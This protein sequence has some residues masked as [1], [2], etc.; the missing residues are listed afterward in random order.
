MFLG[1]KCWRGKEL[2]EEWLRETGI[3]LGLPL[4]LVEREV[5][6]YDTLE[7]ICSLSPVPL[8]LKGGTLISRLYSERPRFSWDIDLSAN[9]SSK[10]ALDLRSLNRS[11]DARRRMCSLKLGGN[12]RIKFGEIVRD[13]EKDVFVDL[14]S[15]K[16]DM[17]TWNLGTPLPT[18]A[19]KL[20]LRF[21]KLRGRLMELKRRLGRLPLV[22]SVRLTVSL[23]LPESAFRKRKVRSLLQSQ[24]P[25]ARTVRAPVYPPEFCLLEKLA[26]MSKELETIGMRDL[27][28]DFY[29]AGQ[30]LKL[31]LF[32][33]RLLSYGRELYRRKALLS[34]ETMRRRLERNL[35]IIRMNLDQLKK[36]REFIWCQY[37]WKGYFAATTR[38]IKRV[39]NTLRQ[40]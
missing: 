19:K 15:L 25:P 11:L 40:S 2:A 34:P 39:L 32:K 16:R 28:C 8:V 17:L 20:G 35:S 5:V 9:L 10:E 1:V 13:T 14:L 4:P 33:K 22:E 38:G 12:L 7:A 3:A 31:E 37:N 6:L 30:L 36:R 23:G 24:L 21:K 18:Y 27:L 26:R 29:D